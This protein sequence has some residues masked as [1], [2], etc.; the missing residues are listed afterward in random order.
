MTMTNA[1]S[2]PNAYT[3]GAAPVAAEDEARIARR[4]ALLG[5]AYRLF[6]E[7]PLHLVR[8]EGVWLYDRDGRAY[9]DT[10][11]NVASVG[12][13]HPRVVEAMARQAATLATHTRYLHDG[14]LDYAERLLAL[15]PP[16]LAHVMFTCTGSEANDLAFRIARARTGGTGIIV[17]DNAYHGVTLAT[18]EASMSIGPATAPGPTVFSVPAPSTAN[19]PEGIAA[20]FAAAITAATERMAG[21]GI[22]PCAL[23]VDTIFSSDGVLP[24]PAG[25]LAPAVAAIHAAGGLFIAD[26]VQPG[27]GRTGA[28]MWGF[29]RHGLL[30]DMVSL[31]K[32]MGNGY[33]LAGLVVQP[34]IVADFGANARYFNTFGGNAVASAVGLAVLDVIRDEGLMEN[35]DTVGKAFAT[36]LRSLAQRHDA[37][38]ETRAAGLF[39]GTDI[40]TQGQPD[41][42]RAGR[43]VNELRREGILISA[44]GPKGHILKIR[45]PLPFSLANVDQFLTTFDRVLGRP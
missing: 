5:P 22:K 33:P 12:H 4:A 14:I 24:D 45:P 17:T 25:F 37:L 18:A 6:Y 20:G 34:Q 13:C 41:G 32:P 7:Q 19:Y 1:P 38:G 36:G 26:E 10:Y 30:P 39:L 21:Q 8:G 2:M 16:A 28:Q 29:E 11:N 9:L 15:F 23:I 42:L 40:V 31:G 44:T 3:P 27:F 43:L 35:A